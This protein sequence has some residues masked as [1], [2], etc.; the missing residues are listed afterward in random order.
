MVWLHPRVYSVWPKAALF[1][2]CCI[3]SAIYVLRGLGIWHPPKNSGPEN[4]SNCIHL[5]VSYNMNFNWNIG[6]SVP[7]ISEMICLLLRRGITCV[8]YFGRGI[9]SLFENPFQ[10]I[11]CDDRLSHITP[12]LAIQQTLISMHLL[13]WCCGDY[14]NYWLAK[15]SNV[16]TLHILYALF[17]WLVAFWFSNIFKV[18]QT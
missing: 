11:C 17:G 16:C 3:V 13:S 18:Q 14:A 7:P 8:K 2:K 5:F 6:W 9:F 1:L 10:T 15:I 12:S 4:F